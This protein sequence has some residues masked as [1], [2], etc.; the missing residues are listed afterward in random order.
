MA[1]AKVGH[2]RGGYGWSTQ[3]AA[4]AVP[5]M[6]LTSPDYPSWTKLPSASVMFRTYVL[7]A[8]RTMTAA[9]SAATITYAHEVTLRATLQH[10]GVGLPGKRIVLY[11]RWITPK[12]SGRWWYLAARTSDRQGTVQASDRPPVTVQYQWRYASTRS[13][14]RRVRVAT[15]VSAHFAAA[16]LAVGA[17]ARLTGSAAPRHPGYLVDLQR[18]YPANGEVLWR[19][20][21]RARLSAAS[22]FALAFRVTSTD[23]GLY[24][25]RAPADPFHA[26][27]VTIVQLW[28]GAAAHPR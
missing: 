21:A 28:V 9:A 20:V 27:G 1:T 16:R 14:I 5:D 3:A 15:M 23:A 24:R 18:P 8:G 12:A 11:R 19:T 25:V 22:T 4:N 13:E 7:A 17:V 26:M 2:D 10:D 6:W